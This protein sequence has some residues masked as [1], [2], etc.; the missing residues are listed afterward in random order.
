[1]VNV[2]SLSRSTAPEE[3]IVY[4]SNRKVEVKAI[5]SK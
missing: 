1:M 3:G 4:D 2:T 5:F